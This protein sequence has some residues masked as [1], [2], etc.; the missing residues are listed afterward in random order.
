[1]APLK[2]VKSLSL[3]AES[4]VVNMLSK[5]KWEWDMKDDDEDDEKH[6]IIHKL[7]AYFNEY[8]NGNTSDQILQS[9]CAHF[10]RHREENVLALAVRVV[11]HR[12]TVRTFKP[13]GHDIN[14]FELDRKLKEDTIVGIKEFLFR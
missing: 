7:Q 10:D 13:C 14:I 12:D 1:M 2:R 6:K 11:L 8:T 5:I 3:L 9:C 4:T